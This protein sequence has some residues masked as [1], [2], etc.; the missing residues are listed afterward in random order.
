M[1]MNPNDLN[2]LFPQERTAIDENRLMRQNFLG[3]LSLPSGKLIAGDIVSTTL[4]PSFFRAISPGSYPVTIYTSP[5]PDHSVRVTH[6]K[7]EFQSGIPMRWECAVPD[8]NTLHSLTDGECIG[9]PVESGIF[10]LMD[11][12]L[13]NQLQ[14]SRDSLIASILATGWSPSP[15]LSPLADDHQLLLV[16]AGDGD[17]AAFGFWG[18][19]SK[20]APLCLVI[21]FMAETQAS[22]SLASFPLH[23]K[24]GKD[25]VDLIGANGIQFASCPDFERAQTVLSALDYYYQ[26]KWPQD[27][28]KHPFPFSPPFVMEARNNRY[29]I[30]D[31]NGT[32]VAHCDH[33][34]DANVLQYALHLYFQLCQSPLSR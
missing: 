17:C 7:V 3:H 33:E 22:P 29:H 20:G 14:N 27:W 32:C 23:L 5:V 31:K 25:G 28:T 26:Q 1:A 21:K 16:P 18:M 30:L 15:R 34:S 2:I 24:T 8:E 13:K 9:Y 6:I 4:E 12:Q 10:F 19:D 11:H